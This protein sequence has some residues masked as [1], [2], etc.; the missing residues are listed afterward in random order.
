[1]DSCDT[2]SFVTG[3]FPA[4]LLLDDL[5]HSFLMSESWFWTPHAYLPLGFMHHIMPTLAQ[6][7]KKAWTATYLAYH[8]ADELDKGGKGRT[9]QEP[10]KWNGTSV[11]TNISSFSL[12]HFLLLLKKHGVGL[13][14]RENCPQ[15]AYLEDNSIFFS[16]IS[17]RSF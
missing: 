1:M 16:F 2:Q 9:P 8:H 17:L 3:F 10:V 15:S 4:Y 5:S 13:K 14:S 11:L 6:I 7:L 12:S